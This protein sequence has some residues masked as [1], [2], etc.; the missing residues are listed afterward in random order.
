MKI[1]LFF[2]SFVL[3][4]SLKN[5]EATVSSISTVKYVNICDSI[6]MDSTVDVGAQINSVI[7]NVPENTVIYFCPAT[8]LINT[9][10][11]ANKRLN[12]V[13]N[14]ATLK[15]TA[16]TNIMYLLADN[17]TVKNFL[18]RGTGKNSGSTSQ[19]GIR[20]SGGRNLISE[21]RFDDFG[22]SGIRAAFSSSATAT[23][24]MIDNCQ[25]YNNNIAIDEVQ[26]GSGEYITV[27]GGLYS[28]NNTAIKLGPGNAK[29]IGVNL[30]YNAVGIDQVANSNDGHGVISDCDVN[31][32]AIGYRSVGTVTSGMEIIG[33]KF[34]ATTIVLTSNVG[35]RFKHCAFRQVTT[36]LT[37]NIGCSFDDGLIDTQ[38]PFIINWV[39]TNTVRFRRNDPLWGNIKDSITKSSNYTITEIDNDIL[40]TGTIN[41]TL[42]TAEK[43][44][45]SEFMVTN[46]GSG[47]VTIVGTVVV[48]GVSTVNPTLAAGHFMRFNSDATTYRCTGKT[49]T[50]VEGGSSG[51]GRVLIQ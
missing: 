32:S 2:I 5:K 44:F 42:P 35:I 20:V 23:G 33:T 10:I 4:V 46:I 41:I 17:S 13:S 45:D 50:A 9:T 1:I 22:G 7:S 16:N 37:N 27:N 38:Y 49:Q 29:V 14:Y 19:W 21:C 8:Y 24:M 15:T 30:T 12:F 3:L 34:Y 31:H 51:T 6:T 43:K 40:A 26:N 47:T 11:Q 18:F 28:Q 36:T 39:G 25:G 48:D